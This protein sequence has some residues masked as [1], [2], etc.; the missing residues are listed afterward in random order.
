MIKT[1]TLTGP[2]QLEIVEAKILFLLEV[3]VGFYVLGSIL[4]NKAH[5]R[6][7]VITWWKYLPINAMSLRVLQSDRNHERPYEFLSAVLPGR[8]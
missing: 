2:V 5:A 3:V 6:P 7:A 1:L 8:V 4:R